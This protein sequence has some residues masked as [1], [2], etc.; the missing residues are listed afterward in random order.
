MNIFQA[1]K[2]AGLVGGDAVNSGGNVYIVEIRNP[3]RGTVLCL[4]DGGWWCESS[5]DGEHLL[6]GDAC[7]A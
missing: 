2:L 5:V 4:G 7:G 3:E 6:D 1:E